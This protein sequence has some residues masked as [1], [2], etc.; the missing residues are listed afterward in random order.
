MAKRYDIV[1]VGAGAAGCVL[2]SRLTEDPDRQ[3]LLIEAGPPDKSWLLHLPMAVAKVWSNP[4]FNWSYES[5]AEPHAAGRRIFHPRGKVLGGST[6][7]NMMSYVRGHRADFDRWRDNG[8]PSWGYR[9]VLPYFKRSESWEGGAST[10]R[11][12]DG[13]LGVSTSKAPDEAYDA[14]LASASEMGYGLAKDYNGAD[15]EGFARTQHL[16]SRG[17][18]SSGAATYLKRAQGRPNLD[19][20]TGVHATQILFEGSRAVGI[21]YLSLGQR[22]Q[23]RSEGEIILAGG[24]YN[25]PQLLM[26]SGI[27]PSNHLK[28]LGIPVKLDL[29]NVGRNLQDHGALRFA[30]R[31]KRPSRSRQELRYDRLAVSALEALALRKGFLSEAPGGGTAFIRS[32]RDQTIPDLEI[33]CANFPF[34]AHEWFPGIQPPEYDGFAFKTCHLRPTSRGWVELASADP[35]EAPRFTVNFLGTDADM[36]AHRES[37]HR[38]REIVATRAFREIAGAE[39]EPGPDIRSASEIDAHI[40]QSVETIFH[41]CGTCRM[42]SDPASVVDLDFRVRGASNLRVVDASVMPDLVGATINA[43]VMM[44]AE[45]AADLL[46]GKAPLP[47]MAEA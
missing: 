9:D 35:T 11:G 20:L 41:P 22:R 44:I 2:A 28:A 29:P 40:R 18:R 24:A 37:I 23:I 12:G 45:R 34:T 3:V 5:E 7:I 39:V 42:G 31:R 27:G 19:I 47:P 8:L 13:P 16:V 30:Y 38:I 17:R 4:R 36:K 6:S 15:Q 10:Y 25:S 33:F 43:P 14:F 21:E 1:I 26:L 46:R 32:D